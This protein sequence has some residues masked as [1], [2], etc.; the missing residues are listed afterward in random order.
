MPTIKKIEKKIPPKLSELMK[1]SGL[2]PRKVAFLYKKFKVATIPALEKL[3][4]THQLLKLFGWGEKSEQN[5]SEG[6]G[7][8]KKFKERFPLGQIYPEVI[9]RGQGRFKNLTQQL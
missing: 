6:L 1:I 9:K 5:I 3:L 2:G 4:K 7:L 8:Y